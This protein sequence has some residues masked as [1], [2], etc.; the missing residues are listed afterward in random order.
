MRRDF[1]FL[2]LLFL[3]LIFYNILIFNIFRKEQKKEIIKEETKKETIESKKFNVERD[4]PLIIES[5]IY[6][7][8]IDP[9]RG[10]IYKI[11]LKKY[12]DENKNEVVLI[13]SPLF[14]FLEDTLKFYKYSGENKIFIDEKESIFVEFEGKDKRFKKYRFYGDSY[15]FNYS[16]GNYGEVFVYFIQPL[17]KKEDLKENQLFIY[18]DSKFKKFDR[19]KFSEYNFTEKTNWITSKSMYFI[20]SIIPSEDGI[21]SLLKKINE[22]YFS[23][24]FKKEKISFEGYAGP[25]DYFILKDI[26]YGLEGVYP[27]GFG[28]IKPFTL[29]I[30]Y[31][32]RTFAKFI[33][34]Y[35]LIIIIFSLLMKIIFMPLSIK[36]LKSMQK[37]SQ[38]QPRLK[39]IQKAY[40][41][42]PK[43]LQEETFKIYKEM[44]VN[45]FS[46]CLPLL[47]QLPIFW[48]LYQVLR[49]DIMFRK[50]PFI[51]WIKDLSFKDP[52]Y[53][54]PV[55]MG[56]TSI[57]QQLLQPAQEKQTRNIGFFMSAFITI[58]FL[59]FPAGLVLYWLIYNVWSIFETLTLKK[60]G[61]KK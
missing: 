16:S 46:G 61:F 39:A 4:N 5:K 31:I 47:L 30:L 32:F 24:S 38:L 27:S 45:P 40:K 9:S 33:K 21:P 58:I 55:L 56:I 34:N 59:N 42:D 29:S 12:K 1:L 10:V 19:N 52:Y 48:G 41:D 26:G 8:Y 51:L 2:I 54:L 57:F 28:V 13:D 17:D 44:G 43:R 14:M 20:F 3:F 50:A 37:L 15:K 7:I 60:M 23:L 53:V 36:S 11:E 22:N 35:G 25:L 49:Y 6:K 18:E